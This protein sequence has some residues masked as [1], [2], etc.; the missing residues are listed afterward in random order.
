MLFRSIA[1]AA[2]PWIIM[3]GFILGSMKGL[4]GLG[5]TLLWAGIA[6]FSLVAFFQLITLPVE[7]DASARAKAQLVKLGLVTG[8]ENVSVDRVLSAAALTYVAAMLNAVM[9]LIRLVL[10]ARGRNDDR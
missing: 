5:N 9:E 3:G 8:R 10:I 2:S 4:A 1:S 7:Y 6:L